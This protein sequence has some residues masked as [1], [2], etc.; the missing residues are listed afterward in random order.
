MYPC[1]FHLLLIKFYLHCFLV[2][3]PAQ[4]D[5]EMVRNYD[6]YTH[7]QSP[8]LYVVLIIDYCFHAV[9]IVDVAILFLSFSCVFI[10]MNDN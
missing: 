6:P 9:Q 2:L 10:L 7:L 3:L 4:N 8:N 1:I 5:Q